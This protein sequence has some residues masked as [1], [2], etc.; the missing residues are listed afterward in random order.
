[1]YHGYALAGLLLASGVILLVAETLLPTHGLLA[2]T[3]GCAAMAAVFIASRENAM[4]GLALL[5]VCA[6]ATPFVWTAFV[7]LWPRTPVGRRLVLQDL[8]AP[9]PP[10]PVRI[11]QAGVAISELRPMGTC[12][13]DGMRIEALSE[14]GIVQAGT[15][16]K[17]VA[18]VNNRPT[19]RVA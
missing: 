7:K 6:V 18:L 2:I 17:V 5:C 11:G 12:E 15:N 10:P 3:G 1:M 14:H 13:F 8:A 19:V 16:V 9:P 4:V